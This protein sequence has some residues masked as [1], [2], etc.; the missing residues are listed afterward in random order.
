MI[1][2]A[3]EPKVPNED[4][5]DAETPPG[6]AKLPFTR[7][8][9]VIAGSLFVLALAI[10]IRTLAPD[11]LYGDSGEFQVLAITGGL[12]HAFGYPVYLAIAK[13]FTFLPFESA[14]ARVSLLSAVLACS[15]IAKVFLISRSLGVRRF[16]S[17][18]GA[19]ALMISPLFWWQS[20]IAEVYTVAADCLAGC[21][22][23]AILWRCTRN[24]WWLAA[25]GLLGGLSLG[26]HHSVLLS[27]P[28][29]IAYL[30]IAKA[31]RRDWGLSTAGALGGAA[32]ALVAYL[33]MGSINSPPTS[34]N[35]MRPVASHFGLKSSDFDDPLTRIKFVF[36]GTQFRREFQTSHFAPNISRVKEE[37]ANDFGWAVPL[38]AI[39]GILSLGVKRGHRKEAALLIGTFGMVLLIPMFLNAFD[40]DVEFINAHLLMC[41]FA[42]VGL[43]RIQDLTLKEQPGHRMAW[44]TAFVAG[45]VLVVA[46]WSILAGA[47]DAILAGKT[48][49][50][51]GVR[52]IFPY[53]V[54]FP[55]RLHDTAAAVLPE[56]PDKAL[57]L[58][59][60]SKIGAFYYVALFELNKPN[61]EIAAPYPRTP[62]PPAESEFF[63][64]FYREKAKT[65]PIFSDGAPEALDYD[66]MQRPVV[67]GESGKVYLYSVAPRHP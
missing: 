21:L 15:A 1:R 54:D 55:T 43:Q 36:T 13:L 58:I 60:W 27:L 53:E 38:L 5:V 16:Y 52:R 17:L 50:L 59:D 3:S 37:I 33:I 51:T 34:T 18:L 65:M 12:A 66:F 11:L 22:L 30:F 28:F 2:A 48:T 25:G 61:I 56:V 32:I 10:Y 41:I 35:F 67:V 7:K 4:A 62:I 19:L 63:K 8:D 57:L 29:V 40:L 14:P 24:G 9:L 6:R 42:A 26:M 46:D 49:F 31:T 20:I 23:F 44:A 45:L 47:R 64:A 39:V